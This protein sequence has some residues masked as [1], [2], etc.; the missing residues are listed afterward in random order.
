MIAGQAVT[1]PIIVRN[2]TDA[3]PDTAHPSSQGYAAI[4]FNAANGT[5]LWR[6]RVGYRWF[7]A[8]GN[9]VGS[10]A[11]DLPADVAAGATSS[12]FGLAVTPPSTAG[13]YT[14]RLDLVHAY[15]GASTLWSSD[16][17]SPS[18]YYSRDKRIAG[19]DSTR[20]TGSSVIERDE[21]GITVGAGGG[22]ATG[23]LRSVGLGDGS[24]LGI[25]LATRN[26]HLEGDTG[27]GF[28]DLGTHLGLCPA[29]RFLDT[30]GLG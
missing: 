7:D 4:T 16:W 3:F 20:W 12:T 30:F 29:S 1:L 27:L 21:F 18:K 23:D 22:T 15:N 25:N 11:Q 6:Y 19:T 10:G 2:T 5:D 14:L 9:V 28:D 24:S 17:A 26:L 13:Q 8:R